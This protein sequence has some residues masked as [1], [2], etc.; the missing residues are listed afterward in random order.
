[1]ATRPATAMYD[2]FG[3]AKVFQNLEG[4]VGKAYMDLAS[5]QNIK[6]IKYVLN[7]LIISQQFICR[8]LPPLVPLIIADRK[9]T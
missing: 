2:V 3:H 7:C 5:R 8:P 4:I 6:K 1:M 9:Q